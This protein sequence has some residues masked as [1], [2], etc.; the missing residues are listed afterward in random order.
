M[1]D[2]LAA[3]RVTRDPDCRTV[4]TALLK[5]VCWPQT[6]A[7]CWLATAASTPANLPHGYRQGLELLDKA[8]AR[9]AEEAAA[10]ATGEDLASMSNNEQLFF[11]AHQEKIPNREYVD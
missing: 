11:N 8:L 2:G 5:A 1:K 6:V 10:E 3:F 7:A 4:P 9:A